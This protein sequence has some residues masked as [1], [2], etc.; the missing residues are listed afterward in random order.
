[1]AFG[2][3]EHTQR[4]RLV[5]V[6]N[7]P[8]KVTLFAWLAAL[9]IG[10]LP[11]CAT[12]LGTIGAMLGQRGDGRL[13]VREAPPALAASR[14]GLQE[15]DEILLIDGQDVRRMNER[16]VHAA[17]SGGAG[18]K[19][20]ITVIRGDAVVRATLTRGEAPRKAAPAK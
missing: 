3:A 6:R 20:K 15:G 16:E 1:M 4:K 12:P 13:F 2:W 19:V 11:G 7:D 8:C 18:S 10:G 17:L 9:G 14:S 5:K